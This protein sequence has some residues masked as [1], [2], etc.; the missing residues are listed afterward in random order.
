MVYDIKTFF[1]MWFTQCWRIVFGNKKS[2]SGIPGGE[3]AKVVVVTQKKNWKCLGR[4]AESEKKE[5]GKATERG[6]GLRLHE[7][8]GREIRLGHSQ[9]TGKIRSL[10]LLAELRWG[11]AAQMKEPRHE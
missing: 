5:R 6:Y 7:E 11:E 2:W 9:E 3:G 1:G 8:T 4:K 10:G